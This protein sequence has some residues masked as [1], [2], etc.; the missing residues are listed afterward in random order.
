MDV[1]EEATDHNEVLDYAGTKTPHGSSWWDNPTPE[2][3]RQQ[4]KWLAGLVSAGTFAYW[5][6]LFYECRPALD[7]F[8]VGPFM[9][10][11][12]TFAWASVGWYAAS[13]ARDS[14]Q[15]SA[16]RRWAWGLLSIAAWFL[17]AYSFARADN[18]VFSLAVRYRVAQAGGAEA[19][20]E[21]WTEWYLTLPPDGGSNPDSPD[22]TRGT[23]MPFHNIP[24]GGGVVTLKPPSKVPP[25]LYKIRSALNAHRGGA[26]ENVLRI[27][28]VAFPNYYTVE[29]Y[30]SGHSPSRDPTLWQHI[31][32]GRR[33]IADGIWVGVEFYDK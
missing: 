10:W 8:C 16:V 13:V 4:V 28:A 11:I 29:I 20:R 24:P 14:G 18:D 15:P 5:V 2:E 9:P 21:E 25:G 27:S 33:E 1:A 7:L 12:L 31:S 17:A 22:A 19:I 23:S 30:A 26:S 3:Q 6:G 32:G